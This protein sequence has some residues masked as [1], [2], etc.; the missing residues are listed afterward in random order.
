MVVVDQSQNVV[1]AI[2][3]QPIEEGVSWN[4]P[5]INRDRIAAERTDTV[6]VL[7][8]WNEGAA[9]TT[10]MELLSHAS[11]CEQF[12]ETCVDAAVADKLRQLARDYR[13]LAEQ[14]PKYTFGCEEASYGPPQ[15]PPTCPT[16]RRVWSDGFTASKPS[17]TRRSV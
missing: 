13:D 11:R 1:P 6:A 16:S 7:R 17:K 10:V 3:F 15:F 14:Q 5:T 4:S 2:F 9:M 8:P 12:A